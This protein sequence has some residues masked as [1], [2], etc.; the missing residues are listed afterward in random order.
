MDSQWTGYPS[1]DKPW[2]KYYSDEALH[3]DYEESSIY[4]HIFECMKNEGFENEVAISF[5]GTKL[6]YF[7]LKKR[8][9]ELAEVLSARGI[10]KEDKVSLCLPILPETV[11]LFLALNKIGAIANFIDP[12]INALRIKEFLGTDTKLLFSIDIYNDKIGKVADELAIA[13]CVEISAA[14]SLPL[15]L[16]LAYRVKMHN[17]A[18]K[19]F[20]SWNNFVTK[21]GRKSLTSVNT[22]P[23]DVAA[24]VYTSGTTGV[25][26][27]AMLTNRSLTA[28][29]FANKHVLPDM[30]KGDSLLD[31]MPPFLAYGLACGICAPL[32]EGMELQLIPK[33]EPEELGKLVRKNKPNNIVGVPYFFELIAKDKKMKDLSFIKYFIAGGDKMTVSSEQFIN[34]FI[35]KRNIKHPVIKGYGMTEL[36]S[37]VI[38]CINDECNKTG[39]VG[40]PLCRNNIMVWDSNQNRELKYG[41]E[42]EIFITGPSVM[43]GYSNNTKDEEILFK[44]IDGVR[45]VDTGDLGYVDEDGNVF[46]SSRKKRM[47]V[48]P[49]G[50]NVFPVA[51][52]EVVSEHPD[53]EAVHVIGVANQEGDNGKIPTACIVFKPSCK[54]SSK[55]IEEIKELSL[56]KLPP[57]DVALKYVVIDKVPMSSV[58][59]VDYR[60]LEEIVDNRG[61]ID[62]R[63]GEMINT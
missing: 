47:I 45:W 3:K 13:N 6:R 44:E 7:E 36:S 54:N 49:D 60:K 50:H 63:S 51:I 10:E 32:A 42:G 2:Q 40:Q 20:E 29:C 18:H 31:I 58:G 21:S 61:G 62:Y 19:D 9:D 38:I 5:Y 24:I 25:P 22:E 59:K 33:F 17:K 52:E 57:R 46:I 16:K 11:Y 1:K 41:Q 12:R 8:V 23:D 39:S 34:E 55:A 35:T 43:K 56:E 37:G 48:R 4:L 28:I 15:H 26:K 27:G 53:V 30:V 14:D